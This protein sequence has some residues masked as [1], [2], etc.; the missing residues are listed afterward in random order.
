MTRGIGRAGS[1][2][3]KAAIPIVARLTAL[4]A[5]A[6]V[7][8]GGARVIAAVSDP[9][10][11]AALLR[12]MNETILGRSLR[13][14]SGGGASLTLEV[15]GRRAL[16]LTDASGLPGAEACLAAGVLED[17]NKDELI[18]LFQALAVPRSELRVTSLP[19][20]QAGELVSVGLPVAL[21]ADLLLIELNGVPGEAPSE[22]EPEVARPVRSL[23]AVAA[24]TPVVE[25]QAVPGA[26]R[27]LAGLARAMAPAL[28]A[29]LVKGG[30]DDGAT[31]GPEEMVSHLQGYLED[32]AETVIRQLDL[33]SNQPGGAICMV[34]GATLVEG[35]SVLCAR[36]GE[37]L[38]L[39]VIEGDATQAL[40]AAWAAAKA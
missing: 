1:P 33:V 11:I 7:A 26:T 23:R 31:E 14:E 28:M 3:N 30:P 2:L 34:L 36:S 15:A 9:S 20:G 19:M 29:W 35:H 5:A 17:E 38:L 24:P 27:D 21:L 12:E 18:K 37:G 39:G 16:R 40:L 8:P 22:P 25:E 4:Q 32:E 6:Q 13:F 10:P